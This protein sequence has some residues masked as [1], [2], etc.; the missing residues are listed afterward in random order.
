MDSVLVRADE[1]LYLAK[2]DGRNCV[3]T[4]L[5]GPQA[6]AILPPP[7]RLGDRASSSQWFENGGAGPAP[8]RIAQS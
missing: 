4:R 5:L 2:D 8:R 6:G 7:P 3:R 1:A